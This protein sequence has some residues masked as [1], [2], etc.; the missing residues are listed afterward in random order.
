M[1]AR[2]IKYKTTCYYCKKEKNKG[3]AYLQRIN[4]KWVC[5]CYECYKKRNNK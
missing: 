4:F 5:Q 1:M 3:E 2:V